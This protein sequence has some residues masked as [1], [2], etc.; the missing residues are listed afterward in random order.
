MMVS[1]DDAQA[2]NAKGGFIKSSGLRGFALWQAGSDS[3]DILLD[4][5]LGGISA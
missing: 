3:K 2:F 1:F 4:S 5:I